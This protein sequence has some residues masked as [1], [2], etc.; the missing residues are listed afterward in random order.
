M[1]KILLFLF[2][3]ISINTVVGQ[4]E[5]MNKAQLVSFLNKELSQ[6]NGKSTKHEDGNVESVNG[7]GVSF[8]KGMLTIT[9]SLVSNGKLSS[10]NSY[11]FS[12]MNIESV[13][14]GSNDYKRT[15][16]DELGSM[17][18]SVKKQQVLWKTKKSDSEKEEMIW[19]NSMISLSFFYND[20]KSFK[21]I[22][23]ALLRLKA[24]LIAEADPYQSSDSEKKLVELLGK[25]DRYEY[26]N[27]AANYLKLSTNIKLKLAGPWA[28]ISKT[29]KDT[30]LEYN[31]TEETF[32]NTQF[33]W[34]YINL[35]EF[36]PKSGILKLKTTS[37]TFYYEYQRIYKDNSGKP[38]KG[39]GPDFN[40]N[41]ERNPT[42]ENNEGKKDMLKA[43]ELIKEIIKMYGGAAPTV[44]EK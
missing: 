7:T 6:V 36:Y 27:A 10:E 41:F 5:T 31:T 8:N 12:P 42:N 14:D 44:V 18:I 19:H 38:G 15:P 20:N 35:I 34:P 4:V 43:I 25:Y 33:Y 37:G 40:F 11:L 22:E 26:Q 32:Y 1:K 39:T 13:G 17:R 28:F 21:L 2:L 3:S 30:D 24:L 16:T 29:Q 9:Q 23:Q